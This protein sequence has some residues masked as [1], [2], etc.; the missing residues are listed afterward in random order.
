MINPIGFML[1]N[2]CPCGQRFRVSLSL[3]YT[4]TC[5]NDFLSSIPAFC[6]YQALPPALILQLDFREDSQQKVRSS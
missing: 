3:K 6:W 5:R 1:I 4:P 2:T